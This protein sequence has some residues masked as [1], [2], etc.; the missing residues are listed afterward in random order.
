MRELRRWALWVAFA[1]I[2]MAVLVCIGSGFVISP[3]A[4][5]ER[6]A[7]LQSDPAGAPDGVRS[8]TSSRLDAGDF[9]EE[10]QDPP[11]LGIPYLA[12]PNGL[13]LVIL[14]LMAL[15]LVIGNRDGHRSS[16]GSSASSAASSP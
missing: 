8:R 15:P 5:G 1:A 11:G 6:I 2:L 16:A 12:L 3:P 7:A 4:L 14:A 9:G 10:V 13:L